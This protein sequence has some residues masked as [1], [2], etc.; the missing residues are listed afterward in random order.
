MAA[1]II[2]VCSGIAYAWS[3]FQQPLMDKFGC[4]PQQLTMIYT[5]NFWFSAVGFLVLGPI[6]KKKLSVRSEVLLGCIIYAGSIL[7]TS[8]VKKS[9]FMIFLLFGVVRSLGMSFVYPVLMSYAVELYPEKSG[10]A[11]GMMTA[12]F[13]LGAMIWAPLATSIYD[14]TGDISRVF[15][16][17]GTIFAVIMIPLSFLLVNPDSS[18]ENNNPTKIKSS[19]P[20]NSSIELYN[21]NRK[22]LFGIP[23]FYVA[24]CGLTFAVS[25]G[26]LIINQAS[27][28]MQHLFGM[29]A[30]SAALVVSVSSIF[31]VLGRFICGPASDKFGKSQVAFCLVVVT[32][33]MMIGMTLI[34]NQL[35]FT[36]CMLMVVFCYGGINSL[37]PPL[38][39]ELF[40]SKGFIGNYTVF[41]IVY[42]MGSLVGPMVGTS[43]MTYTS[44]YSAK[45]AYG[46][47]L[48]VLGAINLFFI[49]RRMRQKKYEQAGSK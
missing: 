18:A 6:V 24:F 48:A 2:E 31:N 44:S 49:V 39:R 11:S 10:F 46:S 8:M 45:F 20:V 15:F 47:I 27:P 38:T 29:V 23:L 41:Y 28:I 17:L 37:V 5:G 9:F 1:I 33:V 12:G 26:N 22:Q 25:C 16:V 40:G 34:R 43:I 36:I 32:A 14:S 30:T 21:V 13:G 42:A 4:T 7:A 19:L 35:V 3:V